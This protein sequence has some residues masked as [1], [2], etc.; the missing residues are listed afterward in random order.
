MCTKAKFCVLLGEDP[1]SWNNQILLPRPSWFDDDLLIFREAVGK[2]AQGERDAA[3]ELLTKIRSDEMREWFDVHGQW[4]GRHR[5]KRLNIPPPSFSPDQ[6]DTLRSAAKFEKSVFERD[7]YTCR[8]CGLRQVSKEVLYAFEKVVGVEN[9]RT[10]GTNA[11]QHGIIHGF[12]IVADHVV[13]F[14]RGGRTNLDNLVSACPA[15]NYGK[16]AFTVEQMGIEDPR[17]R[18]PVSDNWDGLVSFLPSL[19]LQEDKR[20]QVS[21]QVP[22]GVAI[23]NLRPPSTARCLPEI[24]NAP[25]TGD[26]E[27]CRTCR[28]YEDFGDREQDE[29]GECRRHAPQPNITTSSTNDDL[30]YANWPLVRWNGWCG[31]WKRDPVLD[32]PEKA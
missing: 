13:P 4:S 8:Y 24:L 2:A 19:K 22:T 10:Q 26:E 30:L 11:Q 6:F 16:D 17:A 9:F 7:S 25:I 27:W 3:I 23:S 32:E 29:H 12:K 14:K 31:E 5:A 18:R 28:Y 21:I 20:H 1:S 15:C